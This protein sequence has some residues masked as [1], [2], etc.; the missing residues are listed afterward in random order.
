MPERE[1]NLVG[2]LGEM[3]A[4]RVLQKKFGSDSV[5]A[6]SWR[7]ENSCAIF[8]GNPADDAL[9]YDFVIIDGRRTWYIEVKASLDDPEE[10]ALGS[11]EVRAALERA[12]SRKERFRIL[13][14]RNLRLVP[15]AQFLPNPFDRAS[16]GRF[17]LDEAGLRVRY[18]AA[19]GNG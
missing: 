2:L 10:F 1:A 14:V 17:D 3:F 9:G 15:E 5:G 19:S 7:S 18:R 11:S 4:F 8:P 12:D 6:G 16:K 13:H